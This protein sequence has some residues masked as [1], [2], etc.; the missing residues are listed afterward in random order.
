MH[1]SKTALL[2]DH[3]VGASM[4]SVPRDSLSKVSVKEEA[5]EGDAI[6]LQVSP[7]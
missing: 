3:L 6:A 4:V 7:E 2:L 5:K 1:C